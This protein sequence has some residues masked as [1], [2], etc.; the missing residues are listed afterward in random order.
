MEKLR[1]EKRQKRSFYQYYVTISRADLL[2]MRSASPSFSEHH[3]IHKILATVQ[4]SYEIRLDLF[5]DILEKVVCE[6]DNSFVYSVADRLPIDDKE[7]EKYYTAASEYDAIRQLDLEK[8][9]SVF[10]RDT[11][12]FVDTLLD[13][14]IDQDGYPLESF[15]ENIFSL[16]EENKRLYKIRDYITIKDS[17]FMSLSFC[18][19]KEV[20]DS[21]QEK[22]EEAL[23]CC[24]LDALD[25]ILKEMQK[26][27]WKNWQE[28]LTDMSHFQMG[29]FFAFLGHSTSS[30][31]FDGEFQSRFVSCSL[32][33][34]EFTDTYRSG[35]GFILPPTH[36][37]GAKGKDMYI[38]NNAKSVEGIAD[39]TSIVQMD[40]PKK[41]LA[42]CRSNRE[43]NR[44]NG[45]AAK[46]YSEIV[47]DGFTPIGIFC[48]SDGSKNLNE[49]YRHAQELKKQFPHLSV[50]DID[51]TRY[52]KDDVLY[53]ISIL[54]KQIEYKLTGNYKEY[55]LAYCSHFIK[56]WNEFQS[57]KQK[58]DY[59]EEEI[60][61]LYL[62]NQKLL[63]WDITNEKLFHGDYSLEEIRY[64][65]Y[66]NFL[67]NIEA[68]L[69]GNFYLGSFEQL[70]NRL[71]SGCDKNSLNAAIPG[72]GDFID[73]FPYVSFTAPLI[74]KLEGIK[75]LSFIKMVPI[76]REYEKT[77]TSNELQTALERQSMLIDQ[78]K[79]LETS[80]SRLQQGKKY[81]DQEFY[82]TIASSDIDDKQLEKR[83]NE[84]ECR[85]LEE[86]K[87]TLSG[88]LSSQ[89]QEYSHLAFFH[90]KKKKVLRDSI[91]E[92]QSRIA[93]IT[94]KLEYLDT[95]NAR[96]HA[97]ISFYRQQFESH[98]GVDI[99]KYPELLARAKKFLEQVDEWDLQR[100]LNYIE[101]ELVKLESQIATLQQTLKVLEE[102]GKTI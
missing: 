21:Y 30:S 45:V 62:D 18:C 87:D 40:A 34:P 47:V 31:K 6:G 84:E 49:N 95:E 44:K 12:S 8:F 16:I 15:I 97:D 55:P 11:S 39:Y 81:A 14:F 48:F 92:L 3:E 82:Y 76:L 27:I 100:N 65:L 60:I 66:H 79:E 1:V 71:K 51:I 50:V 58:P 98:V 73:I 4:P 17:I 88:L 68:L 20:V 53:N 91:Q 23:K 85:R 9:R 35:F 78:K 19:S 77:N 38:K 57:L 72:L 46:V 89:E 52:H 28:Y 99:A 80:L 102:G 22:Y 67:Y 83:K 70:Y 29:G 32:Y 36:I 37:V 86:E 54:I 101:S 69:N 93:S 7:K 25:T 90:T 42:D 10:S 59:S 63:S 13:Q 94:S 5:A 24:D 75:P 33:T 74:E 26:L 43:E 56:F 2:R 64:I 61:Q 41:V 96:L